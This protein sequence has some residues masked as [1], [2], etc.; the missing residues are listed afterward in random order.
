MNNHLSHRWPEGPV[1][2]LTLPESQPLQK[3]QRSKKRRVLRII[4]IILL[5]VVVAGGLTTGAYF[6]IMYAAE[7]FPPAA[8]QSSQPAGNQ[9]ALPNPS[10]PVSMSP[11][12]DWTPELFP[13]G[14]PDPD[15]TLS[16]SE[17]E[18]TLKTPQEIYSSALP[19]VVSVSAEQGDGYTTGS[20]VILTADGYIVTNYH[21]VKGGTGLYVTL[22]STEME[23]KAKLIGY[24]EELDVAVLKI[25]AKGLT[26]A[27]LADSDKL[28]VGD[29]VYAIGNPLGY[30]Y[31]TMTDGIVSSLARQ[32]EVEGNNMTL[33]QTS[34]PLNSGNSGG[35]LVDSCGRV[36]G[37][38]VAKI[39]GMSGD[40]VIEGI[41]LVIPITDALPFINHIIHTGTSYRPNLGILCYETVLANG[42]RGIM[43]QETTP[44]TPAHGVLFPNDLI[45]AANGTPVAKLPDLTRILYR[46]G[47]GSTVTLTVQRGIKQLDLSIT[48]YDRLAQ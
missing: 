32:I 44:G 40:A 43:V 21:V 18:G 6:G 27:I 8:P 12:P 19:S 33:I 24:D 23:H 25:D 45:I 2:P 17:E 11:A 35:A 13:W 46:S 29:T 9:P 31:G 41:G 42:Q 28:Q 15:V 30:L 34:V 3:K 48:L 39:T 20:G 26:P 1:R 47:V 16:L 4:F 10:S 14:T 36:T 22:L 38:T 5:C 37:I 7:H